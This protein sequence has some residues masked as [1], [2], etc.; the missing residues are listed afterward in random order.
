MLTALLFAPLP[1]ISCYLWVPASLAYVGPWNKPRDTVKLTLFLK[2]FIPLNFHLT[3]NPRYFLNGIE[4]IHTITSQLM[5]KFFLMSSLLQLPLCWT[6]FPRAAG[7][8]PGEPRR[9]RSNSPAEVERTR[10]L[11]R[12]ASLR[13]RRNRRGPYEAPDSRRRA[14]EFRGPD[15]GCAPGNGSHGARE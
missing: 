12:R 11:G 2:D 3:Y 6:R 1:L 13:R 5:K 9:R 14:L 15:P 8:R 7:A 10:D 4:K